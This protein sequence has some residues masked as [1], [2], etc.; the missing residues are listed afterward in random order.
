MSAA[1]LHVVV[2][3]VPVVGVFFTLAVLIIGA[4]THDRRFVLTGFAFVIVCATGAAI[5]YASGPPAY[6][7]LKP[8]ADPIIR[9]LAE[10]HA[11]I[12]RAAFI[13]T[14]LAGLV[15]IQSLLRTASDREPSRWLTR[16]L[17][18][19][20]LVAAGLL[21]WTAHL[22]GALRHPAARGF[23]ESREAHRTEALRER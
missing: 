10:R 8:N 3:H 11:M 9:D 15:A 4:I 23:A 2:V 17:A 20:I 1:L 19:L 13:V 21:V 18:A 22:G 12:G 5:A 16:A 6:E 14:T 7:Q